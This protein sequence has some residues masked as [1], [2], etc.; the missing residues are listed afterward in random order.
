MDIEHLQLFNPRALRTL[1]LGCGFQQISVTAFSNRYPLRYWLRLLP[2]PA[3]I[4]RFLNRRLWR[5]DL[6][7]MPIS[8]PVG[9][10][11]AVGRKIGR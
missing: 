1:L 10:V 4:K 6:F 11:L 7:A 9:N 5:A 8:L 2:L 3:G